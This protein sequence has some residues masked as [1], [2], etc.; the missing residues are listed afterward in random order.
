LIYSFGKPVLN[1]DFLFRTIVQKIK[2]LNWDRFWEKQVSKTLP[3][4]VVASGLI[5]KQPVVMSAED[6]NFQ[7]LDE[8]A[9]CMKASM[10][11]PGITGDAIRLRVSL[12]L[13]I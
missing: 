11:L 10:L 9:E 4:K 3:L 8:L 1:L 12:C 13:R 2:P 6:N 5:S 7:S